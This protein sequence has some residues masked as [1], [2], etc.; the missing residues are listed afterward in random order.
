MRAPL[1]LPGAASAASAVSAARAGAAAVAIACA[2]LGLGAA[3]LAGCAQPPAAA[4]ATSTPS[5]PPTPHTAPPAPAAAATTAGAVREVAL[6]AVNDFHG[7]LQPADPVPYVVRQPAAADGT[8]VAPQPAGGIAH[9]ATLLQE[10]RRAH[11]ASL[12]VAAGDL[13]G[14]SPLPSALLKDE[15]TLQLLSELDLAY[16]APGNHEFDAGLDELRR[17]IEGRCPTEGCA[18]PSFRKP[19]FEYLAANVVDASGRPVFRPWAVREVGGARIAFVG[20][21]TRDTPRLVKASGIAGLRFLDEATAVN[22][23]LP[24]VRRERPD[25]I[26]LL[27]HE[28]GEYRGPANDPSERC[29]GLA[30]RITQIAPRL[31]ADVSVV[32]SAHTHQ[33]YTCRIDGKLVV[34]GGNA[35]GYLTEVRLTLDTQRHAVLASQAQNLPVLQARLPADATMQTRW[36]AVDAATRATRTQPVGPLPGSY[37]RQ[38]PAPRADWPLGNLITDAQLA[39]GQQAGPTDVALTNPGG[40]RADLAAGSAGA[41]TA[42]LGQLF[43]TQPFGNLLIRMRLKG[44]DLAEALERQSIDGPGAPRLLQISTGSRYRLA[45]LDGRTRLVEAVIAGR[46]LD[47]EREYWVVVND[48][49]VSGGDGFRPLGRGTDQASVGGDLEALIDYVRA[50]RAMAGTSD[51]RVVVEGPR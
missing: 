47:P 51:G 49:L 40:I 24:E 22:A 26:V 46:P 25:A 23:V 39:A 48:F 28:G 32:F 11:P 33:A 37:A 8:T 45:R 17:R 21:V 18:W 42:N 2:A 50:G 7:A 3:G 5:S 41:T 43:A 31:D 29:E 44:R 15:P 16:S 19:G 13:I 6:L 14:A 4:A 27:L 9:L 1:R 35:G 12:F 34:Q 38:A 10:R 20:A 36:Q 30:G